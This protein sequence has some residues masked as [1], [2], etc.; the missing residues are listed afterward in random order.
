M[1]RDTSGD[2]MLL[3]L[4]MHRYMLAR[5]GQAGSAEHHGQTERMDRAMPAMSC[6]IDKLDLSRS[7]LRLGRLGPWFLLFVLTNLLA[8]AEN[9]ID[10][11]GAW[12]FQLDPNDVGIGQGWF[13]NT[14][15]GQIRL[16]G[17]LAEQGVGEPVTPQTKWIGD[18][19]DRSYFTSREYERYRQPGNVKVPFWLQPDLYYAG[20]AWYQRWI[21]IPEDWN[22]KRVILFLER[23][24]WQTMVWLDGRY[25]GSCDA[26]ATPHEYELGNGLA[27]GR[28][29]LTIRVDNRL[30]VDIGVNSHSI[31]DQT[32]GNWNGI[33]GRLELRATPLVWIDQL[34]VWPIVAKGAIVLKGRLG[35]LTGRPA[36]GKMTIDITPGQIKKE[37]S[38]DCPAGGDTFELEIPLGPTP[39]PWDEFDPCL[40][41]L[42]ATLQP[43][44]HSLDVVFGLREL[45][46]TGTQFLLNG[47][48]IFLRGTVDCAVFPKT[49]YPPMD[50]A[51]WKGLISTAKA[52]G[53][54]HIRF[55]SWCPP[56]AAFIAADELGFYYMVECS[57]WANQSTTLGDGRPVDSWVYQEA[58]RIIEAYGNHPCLILMAYGNEPGGAKANAYLAQWV[59]HYK[60]K[61]GRRLYTSGSG[62]PKLPDNQFH[63]TP[64]PRIQAWGAGLRSRI[65]ANPPE[66]CTDYRGYI[67]SHNV[68]VISH[69]IGQWCVY[70]NLNEIPKYSGYLKPRNY[71]IF[72]DRLFDNGMADKAIIF[73]M[74]SGRLQVL[75]YKEEIE[76]ALRTPG[77]AGFQLLALTDFTGQGTATVGILDAFWGSKGYITASGFRRFCDST[78][79]LARL[80]ARVFSTGQVLQADIEM[81]HF[82]PRPLEDVGTYWQLADDNGNIV[83]SGRLPKRSIPIGN[84][85]QIGKIQIG[86]DAIRAPARYRLIVGIDG[87]SIAND[88]DVW[89]YAKEV[90]INPPDE[91]IVA[92]DLDSDAITALRQGRKVLL[93]IPPSRVAPDKTRGRI[94]LGFSTIF[95]NTAWTNRQAPHTMGILCDPNH[96]ALALF[97]T[98][99]HTNWQW[100]Y[101]ISRSAVM[102]LDGFP[103]QLEPIVQVIDDWFT[104]RRLALIFEAKVETGRLLVTSIDLTGHLEDNLVTRQLRHSILRYMSSNLFDP[105]VQLDIQA[106][107]ALINHTNH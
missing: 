44:R 99:Y 53:L 52:Y 16:P 100:W 43:A 61:D 27:P 72:R 73:L 83:A 20:P 74:A 59:R 62:W 68:P 80:P 26:L 96:P 32:Q 82:G 47:R 13:K 9:P 70:P 35:N 54:N 25:I 71:E 55:H 38:F 103:R 101:V 15:S 24:H 49:G 39:R 31:S 6:K 4:V 84:G 58:D 97:P 48:K 17:C 66:T 19:V 78:V 34:Q 77:M 86:L 75:C 60:T 14:L 10:L 46:T 93:C 90:D 65:N 11:A 37:L 79:I 105:K 2:M 40:Y 91:I 69:E 107:L 45:S 3:P 5:P 1:D 23:A 95:W 41:R 29:L 30:I 98:D 87:T 18:I 57:S 56:E 94:E 67:A 106:V 21:R 92:T 81:A 51:S 22:D 36:T 42:T 8:Y 7:D 102:I 104:A 64:D 33:I 12:R 50:V 89:V 28:Y 63:V 85:I 76:S 88:W